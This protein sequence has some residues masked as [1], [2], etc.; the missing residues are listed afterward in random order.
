MDA[1]DTPTPSTDRARLEISLASAT[2]LC[3]LG[4]GTMVDIRQTFE[5]EMKG[6]MPDTVAH[7]AV[8]GQAAAR[9]CADRRRAGHPRCRQAE[10]HRR[11]GLLHDDQPAA[12]R[13]RQHPAVRVQQRPAQPVRRELLRSL[14]YG[15]A[16][17]VAG[18]FQAWKQL[19]RAGRCPGR[20]AQH[21][22]GRLNASARSAAAPR[23]L[24]AVQ[25]QQLLAGAAPMRR[26]GGTASRSAAPSSPAHQA[27]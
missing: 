8:R 16:L 3:R 13:A 26:A 10:R 4:L 24:R 23:R 14:G 12:P 9:P 20:S 22:V 15:K 18:G 6:A 5:I 7:P 1:A 19:Q 25:R 11:A 2:E 27:A 21:P 17:S